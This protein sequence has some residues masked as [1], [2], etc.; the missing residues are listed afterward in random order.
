MST[1]VG[2][3]MQN[4]DLADTVRK[5]SWN[6]RHI[7]GGTAIVTL[8]AL[9]FCTL[10]YRFPGIPQVDVA[11]ATA[12]SKV[13]DAALSARGYIVAHHR[14]FVPEMLRTFL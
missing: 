13:E 8:L 9:V 6:R 4:L 11:R 3:C 1:D 14:C 2:G 7:V 5:P 12:V 10:R